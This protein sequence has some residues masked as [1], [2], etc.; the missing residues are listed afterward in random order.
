M[1]RLE[2]LQ[3]NAHGD[4]DSY[5]GIDDRAAMLMRIANFP[6]EILSLLQLEALIA[7]NALQRYGCD[8]I[9][10]LGCYDGRSIELS[11]SFDLR[12]LGVDIDPHAIEILRKRIA[13]EGMDGRAEAIVANAL[14]VDQWAGRIRGRRSLIHLPFNL[15]GSFRTPAMVLQRLSRLPGALLLISVFN[16]SDYCTHVRQRYYSACGVESLTLTRGAR[17]AA[18]FTGDRHFF[19]Q[20]FTTDMLDRLFAECRIDTLLQM[21]NRLGTCVVVKSRDP[22]EDGR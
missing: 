9:V 11:R 16:T 10:E 21:S 5:Y 4:S 6:D 18:T 22:R 3:A 7:Y 12:Y 8:S 13:G 19:S 14:D 1:S 20:A 15:L 2:V 17:D